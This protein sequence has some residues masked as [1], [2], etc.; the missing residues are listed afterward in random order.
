MLLSIK[1]RIGKTTAVSFF[2]ACGRCGVN[3][4]IGPH[5][6]ILSLSL[7]LPLPEALV[8]SLPRRVKTFGR[9]GSS[10]VNLNP[11]AVELDLMNPSARLMERGQSRWP[12]LVR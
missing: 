11:V 2:R 10:Q 4:T 5:D 9:Y 12:V 3:L 7:S 6:A 8:Q 1:Q